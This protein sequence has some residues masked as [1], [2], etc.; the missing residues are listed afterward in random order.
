MLRIVVNV[1]ETL[2]EHRLAATREACSHTGIG[3]VEDM[4]IAVAV[5]VPEEEVESSI[6]AAQELVAN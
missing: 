3:G 4:R 1:I 6:L 5:K 2:S